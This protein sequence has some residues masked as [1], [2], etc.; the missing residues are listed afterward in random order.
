[1]A[2]CSGG[3]AEGLGAQVFCAEKG[4]LE[5]L[6]AGGDVYFEALASFLLAGVEYFVVRFALDA[7]EVV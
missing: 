3:V 7:V 4:A 6:A 5:L 2:L 1:M